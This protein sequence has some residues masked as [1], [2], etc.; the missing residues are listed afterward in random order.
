MLFAYDA[1]NLHNELYNSSQAGSRD[2]FD[3]AAKFM[4][5]VV[6]NGKVFVAGQTQFIVY[7]LLP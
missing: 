3:L 7:G 6:A 1:T 4:I 2:T 5:P